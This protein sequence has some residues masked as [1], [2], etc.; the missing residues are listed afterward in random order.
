MVNFHLSF[1]IDHSGKSGLQGFAP[2]GPFPFEPIPGR[3]SASTE[4]VLRPYQK[5]VEQ[6]CW[7]ELLGRW[8]HGGSGWSEN[9]TR[10]PAS[11]EEE[12]HVES[13]CV[14]DRNPNVSLPLRIHKMLFTFSGSSV[15][16]GIINSDKIS[17][18]MPN[19]AEAASMP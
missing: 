4:G 5:T 14:M 9:G 6:Y 12:G 11:G 7:R 17:A 13:L 16:I 3:G 15:A 2:A 8:L 10:D 1:C 18:E 19:I